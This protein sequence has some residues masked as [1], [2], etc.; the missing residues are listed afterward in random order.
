MQ[1]RRESIGE[2]SDVPLSCQNEK[3]SCVVGRGEGTLVWD[4]ASE[5]LL[6]IKE[7]TCAYY[8]GGGGRGVN[9][10]NRLVNTKK[11]IILVEASSVGGLFG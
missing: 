8:G 9:A 1:V 5:V 6:D 11:V 10:A 3:T 2:E 7:E 4:S